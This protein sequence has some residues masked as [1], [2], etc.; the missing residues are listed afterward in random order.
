MENKATI[1]TVVCDIHLSRNSICLRCIVFWLTE[2]LAVL[3]IPASIIENDNKGLLYANVCSNW[4]AKSTKLIVHQGTP[5]VITGNKMP[6]NQM[7][8]S[9]LAQQIWWIYFN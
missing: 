4:N 8:G 7:I 6:E 5:T 9:L 2:I 1:N 3:N